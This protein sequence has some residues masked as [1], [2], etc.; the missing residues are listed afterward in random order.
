MKKITL[1]VIA[2]LAAVLSFAVMGAQAHAGDF[3]SG[4]NTIVKKGEIIDQTLFITGNNIEINGEVKGDIF[5]AGQNITINATVRGDIL[6]AGM[7]VRVSGAVEG[8]VRLAGQIVTLGATIGRN[9]SLVG[10]TVTTEEASRVGGDLQVGSSMA[11]INGQVL[12]DVDAAGET[13]TFSNTV[14]RN[15]SAAGTDVH[16]SEGTKVGGNVTYHSDKQLQKSGAVQIAGKVTKEQPISHDTRNDNPLA[17]ALSGGIMFLSMLIVLSLVVAAL[18]PRMLQ[19]VTDNAVTKPGTTA[20]IGLAASVGAPILIIISM[21]TVI[22][23][24][25]G[26]TLLFFWLVVMLLSGVFF[27]YYIGRLV[28]RSN[29]HV[30]LTM[31]VGVAIVFVLSLIPIVNFLT[32]IAIC[33]FGSGMVLRELFHRSPKPNYAVV[34]SAG[35]KKTA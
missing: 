31:L 13:I 25:L 11:S 35:K 10:E 30:L 22:G 19:T 15:V 27:S 16:F 3:R 20:L 2:L 1:I 6:C 34:K 9:A 26:V 33:L 7:N 21:L 24:L 17:T 23:L 14:G 4:N 18:F 32:M 8:D 12:R 28:L 29:Q 5:C